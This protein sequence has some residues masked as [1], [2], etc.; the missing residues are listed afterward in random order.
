MEKYLIQAVQVTCF[1]YPMKYH[2]HNINNHSKGT[3][4][5]I[6]RVIPTFIKK[7]KKKITKSFYSY[8]HT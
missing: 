5:K 7:M 2:F 6:N 4:P 8:D 3:V 1:G